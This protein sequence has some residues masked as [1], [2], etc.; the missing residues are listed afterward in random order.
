MDSVVSGFALMDTRVF[1]RI[2]EGV[3]CGFPDR[4]LGWFCSV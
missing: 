2:L 1:T 4:W 3:L